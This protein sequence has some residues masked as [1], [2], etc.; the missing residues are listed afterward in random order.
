MPKN[1]QGSELEFKRDVVDKNPA[2]FD[3]VVKSKILNKFMGTL[4]IIEKD[5]SKTIVIKDGELQEIY[6][7]LKG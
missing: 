7:H 2:T 1:M 3:S 6:S 4:V 5:K